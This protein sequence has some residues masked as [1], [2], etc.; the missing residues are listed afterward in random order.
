MSTHSVFF[1]LPAFLNIRNEFSMD[2]EE[3]IVTMYMLR[4]CVGCQVKS[5]SQKDHCCLAVSRELIGK[6]LAEEFSKKPL[7]KATSINI[8]QSDKF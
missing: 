1:T 5:A 4:T 7:Q 6:I 8:V 2:T 3:F